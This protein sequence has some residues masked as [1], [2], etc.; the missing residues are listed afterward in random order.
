MATK[1]KK[2]EDNLQI[3]ANALRNHQQSAFG[4]VYVFHGPHPIKRLL[5][6]APW[7][8]LINLKK[9]NDGYLRPND[10]IEVAYCQYVHLGTELHV[11][12]VLETAT[13]LVKRNT[14]E[15]PILSLIGEIVDHR[16]ASDE[17]DDDDSEAGT[18]AKAAAA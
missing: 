14:E 6:P 9:P 3:M 5:D 4:C 10:K 1:K 12:N 13:L 2:V 16:D 11:S 17:A 8:G 15:G 7:K 18:K